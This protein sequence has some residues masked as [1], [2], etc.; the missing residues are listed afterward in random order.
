MAEIKANGDEIINCGESMITLC[1]DYLNQINS[2]FNS[3]SKLNKTA[4]SG[5]SA[6]GYVAKIMIEQKKFIEFG[7][8]LMMYAKVIKN[9]GDNVNRIISKWDDK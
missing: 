9:T 7:D 3:L 4:W 2:L 1:N 6:D 8:Y 5:G